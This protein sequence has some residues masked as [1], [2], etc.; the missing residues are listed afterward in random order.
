VDEIKWL[1]KEPVGVSRKQEYEPSGSTNILAGSGIS[2]S[3]EELIQWV[4]SSS[5]S[6]G[7]GG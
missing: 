2:A 1:E 7:P 5:S 6:V 3:Y 4:N